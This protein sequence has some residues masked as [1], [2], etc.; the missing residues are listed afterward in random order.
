M[1]E[2]RS[3]QELSQFLQFL[4]FCY[5]EKEEQPVNQLTNSETHWV[6]QINYS[7]LFDLVDM[8]SIASS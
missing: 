8:L 5:S 2:V 1:L 6:D 7:Q 4:E 3:Y